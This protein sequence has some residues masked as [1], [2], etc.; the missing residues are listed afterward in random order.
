MT[1]WR[2][3][4][5]GNKVDGYTIRQIQSALRNAGYDPGPIDNVLGART[6]AALTKYQKDNSL[7]IGSLDLKTLQALGVQY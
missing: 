1:E 6:R 7:P 5:C 3:V 2:E 4:L